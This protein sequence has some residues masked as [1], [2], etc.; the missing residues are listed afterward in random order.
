MDAGISTNEN[1]RILKEN[2]FDFI[3]VS[4]SKLSNYKIVEGSRPVEVED[5]KH[6]KIS[7]QKVE[8][9]KYNDFFLKVE[10]QAKRK[11]EESMNNRFREGFETGLR[12][13]EASLS[14]KHGIK[15]EDRVMER[16]GRLKQKYQSVHRHY[17]ID[18]DVETQNFTNRKTKETS[19]VRR[20]KSMS[21]RVGENMEINRTGGTYFLRTPLN[22]AETIVWEGYNVIRE[23]ESCFRTLKTDPDPRPIYHKTD[24][25]TMAHLN[26][27]MPACRVV[28]TVRF[29]LKQNKET[30]VSDNQECSGSASPVNLPPV[31]FCRKETVRILNTQKAVTT[32]AQNNCD[33]II[34]IRRCTEPDAK[35]Q[36]IYN[37]LNYKSQPFTKRKF[38]VHKSEFQKNDFSIYQGVTT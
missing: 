28:N 37:R 21:W 19:E 1:L 12:S 22:D 29:Q 5:G 32:T 33:E 30:A 34:L 3:R 11:R 38:V 18:Y 24:D 31:N 8:S 16:T 2:G 36:A 9:E 6:Q 27:G 17:E 23:E 25:S 26:P 4:R 13:M 15:L 14:R 35:V 10:S 7:L 20:V